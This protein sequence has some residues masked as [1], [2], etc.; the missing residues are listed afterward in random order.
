MT[1]GMDAARLKL[2]EAYVQQFGQLAKK[3]NTMILPA[4]AND[5]AGMVATA[6][7]AMD[8]TREGAREAMAS[9]ATPSAKAP[10]T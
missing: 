9:A 8:T 4:A 3:S 5:V 6:M 2:A 10:R 7:A 1:G